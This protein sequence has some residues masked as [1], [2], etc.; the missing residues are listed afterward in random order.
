VANGE[1]FGTC[2]ALNTECEEGETDLFLFTDNM[3][4][5][6]HIR[7]GLTSPWL[8]MG[9]EHDV[10]I[11]VLLAQISER[12]DV[13]TRVVDGKVVTVASCEGTVRVHL[14]K[15]RAHTGVRGNAVADSFAKH[16][17]HSSGTPQVQAPPGKG[18]NMNCSFRVTP[19]GGAC[20][21]LG[22]ARR[23]S[24]NICRRCYRGGTPFRT[25]LVFKT[26]RRKPGRIAR[27]HF[28]SPEPYKSF[29]SM[30]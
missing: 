6:R 14:H 10:T 17:C 11:K 18:V 22:T 25:G 28:G 12:G 30:S 7:K 15:V 13:R 9:H 29:T 4:T 2:E 8:L 5:I 1:L 24:E 27:R 20:W 21:I 16:A 23:L 3:V 19:V 26:G